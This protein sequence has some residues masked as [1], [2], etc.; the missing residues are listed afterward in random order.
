MSSGGNGGVERGRY[1]N[2]RHLTEQAAVLKQF[3]QEWVRERWGA[4]ADEIADV[5][6]MDYLDRECSG[7][8]TA[9]RIVPEVMGWAGMSQDLIER[10]LAQMGFRNELE[11][12]NLA[13]RGRVLGESNLETSADR[14][15]D[16]LRERMRIEPGYRRA[17]LWE[18]FG[19]RE[20]ALSEAVV[21][22]S[23]PTNGHTN[24]HNGHA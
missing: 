3:G 4:R 19:I 16:L 5:L 11:L 23:A 21:V 2:R 9:L 6:L 20:A 13:N 7:H 18:L 10:W 14:A 17:L 12:L 24:G 15:K 1:G 22:E 8:R